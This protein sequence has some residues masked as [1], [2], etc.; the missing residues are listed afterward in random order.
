M[1]LQQTI[2]LDQDAVDSGINAQRA[3][4]MMRITG[5]AVSAQNLQIVEF[6]PHAPGRFASIAPP[7]VGEELADQHC[8]AVF[9]LIKIY[10]RS[11]HTEDSEIN[12]LPGYPHLRQ[13]I[14]PEAIIERILCGKM[15]DMIFWHGYVFPLLQFPCREQA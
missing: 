15:S 3:D 14:M 5:K 6:S 12:R 1:G 10:F 8:V 13:D 11:L 2:F 7:F 9:F 4:H